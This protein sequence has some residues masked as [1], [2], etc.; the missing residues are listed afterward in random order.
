MRLSPEFYKDARSLRPES[1]RGGC[2]FGTGTVQFSRF[3]FRDNLVCCL[4]TS[5]PQ[6]RYIQTVFPYSTEIQVKQGSGASIRIKSSLLQTN[7]SKVTA[8]S[9]K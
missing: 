5:K 4:Q 7:D 1:F 9:R 8:S 6:N 3:I 2:S